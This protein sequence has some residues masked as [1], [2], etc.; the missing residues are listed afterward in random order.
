MMVVVSFH[1]VD[2]HDVELQGA[3]VTL[4]QITLDSQEE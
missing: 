4:Y 2:H 3:Y 1:R